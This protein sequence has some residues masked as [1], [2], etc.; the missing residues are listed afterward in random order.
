MG[1]EA[2]LTIHTGSRGNVTGYWE[3]VRI[4][5]VNRKILAE[6]GGDWHNRVR[7]RNFCI[8][9]HISAR[10]RDEMRSL[11]ARLPNNFC[12]KDPR[13]VW[14]AD[15]WGEFFG[16][17][18]LVGLFRNPA[19]FVRS[20]AHKWPEHYRLDDEAEATLEFWQAA[21]RRLLDLS[22]RYRCL[23][24]CFDD[25][26]PALKERLGLIM[27]ELGGTFDGGAFDSIYIAEERR[28]SDEQYTQESLL[29]LSRPVAELYRELKDAA[30]APLPFRAK[31]IPK[32]R[33]QRKPVPPC[34]LYL[35]L[36]K[37]CLS[38]TL[39]PD[40]S[41]NPGLLPSPGEFDVGTRAL[42]LD[43]PAEAETMIG[44]DRLDNLQYCVADAL[45]R[46]VPGDLVEAGVWRGGAAIFM[47][48]ILEAQGDRTRSVWVVDSFQGLPEPDPA[49]FPADY[50][51]R[52]W[53]LT[54]YLGV[55]QDVVEANFE[56]YQLL[57]DRVKFLSGWFKDTLPS[58]PIEQI[59]V[60]RI[61]ADMYESTYEVLQYLYPKL[62]PGGYV[63]ID[64]WG[65]LPK[66]AAAVH[67]YRRDHGIDEEIWQADWSAV[68]WKKR[69]HIAAQ[70][71]PPDLIS[72]SD[73]VVVRSRDMPTGLTVDEGVQ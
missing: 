23:W 12:S 32:R 36:M 71:G 18:T 39:F 67:D 10:L 33:K 41:I 43:W 37:Q 27:R 40:E 63:I 62:Q 72:E 1:Q 5:D 38:R 58:A 42:G 65:V 8:P 14:T 31:V 59:A 29:Q 7:E 46:G 47:R 9:A 51:D 50:G 4:Q 69:C 28:Y 54:P 52:H 17:I 60:L 30:S 35:D 49:N 66:C 25:P 45:A 73:T 53:E 61:D 44:L 24:L 48:A 2:E 3:H 21:N 15:F 70:E 56:R 11:T 57:D 34:T 68:Y 22:R 26:V 6:N 64:D 55:P 20:L 13:H 19:G 16:D